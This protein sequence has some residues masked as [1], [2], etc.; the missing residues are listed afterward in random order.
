MPATE[1]LFA[2]T[3]LRSVIR[4]GSTHKVDS[5]FQ[6]GRSQGM[7]RLDD[8]LFRLASEGIVSGPDAYRR[9]NDKSRFD[10]F[11]PPPEDE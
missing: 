2:T 1:L 7:H 4:E 10:R 6:A 3:A 9:A 8:D 11:L 5:L